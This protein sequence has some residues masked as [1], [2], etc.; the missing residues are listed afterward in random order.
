ML[1][2]TYYTWMDIDS[3]RLDCSSFFFFLL[4]QNKSFFFFFS[5]FWDSIDHVIRLGMIGII[6]VL[7]GSMLYADSDVED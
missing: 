5:L 2:D 4:S 6:L 7:F 1:F 3:C